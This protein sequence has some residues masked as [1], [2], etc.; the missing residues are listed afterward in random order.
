MYRPQLVE[1]LLPDLRPSLLNFLEHSCDG[2]LFRADLGYSGHYLIAHHP[3]RTTLI[4]PV[5]K[6]YKLEVDKLVK[7]I[8]N[9]EEHRL[10]LGRSQALDYVPHYPTVVGLKIWTDDMLLPVTLDFPLCRELID[11]LYRMT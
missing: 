3:P 6:L 5:P 10:D 11:T 9:R 4:L 2:W 8:Y 7:A 1:G